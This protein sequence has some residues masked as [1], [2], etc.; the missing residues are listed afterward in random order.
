[1]LYK[2]EEEL[3]ERISAT[4]NASHDDYVDSY[5][6]TI[7]ASDLAVGVTSYYGDATCITTTKSDANS[8]ICADQLSMTITDYIDNG[9]KKAI[10]ESFSP[11][12]SQGTT[13]KYWWDNYSY[14]SW[15]YRY[16]YGQ[17][18]IP[19]TSVSSFTISDQGTVNIG[20]RY[21]IK[22]DYC[23]VKVRKVN[24]KQKY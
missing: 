15:W 19:S 9:V 7:K 16:P 12:R 20:R 23:C 5:C 10:E 6:C 2:N 4:C 17:R 24:F 18:Y 14:G 13:A 3:K 8:S 21:L 11:I 22:T 1:M